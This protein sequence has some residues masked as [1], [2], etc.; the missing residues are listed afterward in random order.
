WRDLC[1]QEE[2]LRNPASRVFHSW[3]GSA[4]QHG[5]RQCRPGLQAEGAALALVVDLRCRWASGAH[6]SKEVT[7]EGLGSKQYSYCWCPGRVSSA[8]HSRSSRHRPGNQG[9]TFQRAVS[10]TRVLFLTPNPVEAAS[11]RYRITQF[12]PYLELH[13]FDCEVAP[14]L[15]SGLFNDFYRPG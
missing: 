1:L 13:G 15:T 9:A 3:N 11:T 5:L 2:V 10:R 14:F 8:I 6:D 4:L 12:L 7:P